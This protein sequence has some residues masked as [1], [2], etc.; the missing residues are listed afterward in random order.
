MSW[1]ERGRVGCVAKLFEGI[2]FPNE[3]TMIK[4]RRN[5]TIREFKKKN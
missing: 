3:G 4:P 5:I 2:L 1:F